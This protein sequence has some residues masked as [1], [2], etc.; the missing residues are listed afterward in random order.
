MK[1]VA[2]VIGVAGVAS[3][4]NW[5][6]ASRLPGLLVADVAALKRLERIH[7]R[8]LLVRRRF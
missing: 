1:S 7:V 8:Q 2:P 3:R 6:S 4:N 5:T